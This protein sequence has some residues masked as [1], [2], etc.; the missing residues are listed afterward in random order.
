MDRYGRNK[1]LD[2]IGESGQEKISSARVLILGVGGVGTNVL[3]NL[4]AL[5]IGHIGIVDYDTVNITN[6]NRQILYDMNSI[7]KYK[8][9]MAKD[10]VVKFNP[11]IDIEAYCLKLDNDNCEE[12]FKN[13]DILVDAFDSHSSVDLINRVSVK[14]NKILIHAAVSK[15]KGVIMTTIPFET[16]CL[17]C[18]LNIEDEEEKE[19]EI[20][21]TGAI[22]PTV[23]MVASFQAFEVIKLI[24]DKGVLIKKEPLI[25][26]GLLGI[27]IR[28]KV[29][30]SE[31]Q[32]CP[33]CGLPLH[34]FQAFEE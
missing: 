18:F 34:S 21:P 33:V 12:I 9:E 13:Y 8:V 3:M 1:L 25:I 20:K 29:Y 5:G 10:W 19:N 14:M 15:A 27:A 11:D 24:L 2:F 28:P 17:R 7:G 30:M 32:F 31:K 26:D 23:S 22:A 6:L 16:P 4:A